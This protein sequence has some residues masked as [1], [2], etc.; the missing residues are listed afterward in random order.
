[1][2]KAQVSTLRA[3]LLDESMQLNVCRAEVLQAQEELAEAE[4]RFR[5]QRVRVSNTIE[6][7]GLAERGIILG[8]AG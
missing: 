8:E 3:R 7:V 2:S 6:E 5:A 1:M 4:A